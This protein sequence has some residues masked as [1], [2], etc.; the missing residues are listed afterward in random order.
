M[1]NVYRLLVDLL[2]LRRQGFGFH[3]VLVEHNLDC[4]IVCSKRVLVH[5]AARIDSLKTVLQMP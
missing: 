1:D 3:R 4:R 5:L 2:E